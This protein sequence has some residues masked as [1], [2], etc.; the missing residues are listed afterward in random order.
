[1][2][3]YEQVNSLGLIMSAIFYAAIGLKAVARPRSLLAA[4][5]IV[6]DESASRN[7]IRAVYGGFP[8]TVSG[9]LILCLFNNS[10]SAGILTALAACSAGMAAGRIVSA[11]ID[12]SLGRAPAVFLIVEIAVAV[13]IASGI[14]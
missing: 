2:L 1:M 8:L 4:F 11:I 14:N 10:L 9:L 5:G 7:E 12:R 6:A 13:A 3:E